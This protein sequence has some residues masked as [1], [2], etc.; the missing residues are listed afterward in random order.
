NATKNIQPLMD[1]PIIKPRL[2]ST[3]GVSEGIK[4]ELIL[5]FKVGLVKVI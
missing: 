3:F 4:L 2:V 5:I 1:T